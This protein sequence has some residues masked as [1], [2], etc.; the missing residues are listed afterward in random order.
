[1]SSVVVSEGVVW[2]VIG[3]S[4]FGSVESVVVRD[5]DDRGDT[6]YLRRYMVSGIVK[7][8]DSVVSYRKSAKSD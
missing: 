4:N 5:L 3:A 7:T 8:R 1:M 6:A 2:P